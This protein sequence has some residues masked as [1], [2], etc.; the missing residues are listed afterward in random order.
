MGIRGVT[1]PVPDEDFNSPKLF[2]HAAIDGEVDAAIED[3]Q[4]LRDASGDHRPQRHLQTVPVPAVVVVIQGDEL[5]NVEYNSGMQG[6]L[7]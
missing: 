7:S 3:E 2:R 4:D 6:T 1:I 5:V